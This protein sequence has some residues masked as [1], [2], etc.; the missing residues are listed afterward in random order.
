VLWL[1]KNLGFL[2]WRFM[3]KK[4]QKL[5]RKKNSAETPQKT[6]FSAVFEMGITPSPQPLYTP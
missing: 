4:K 2:P 6:N 5:P 1:I 3:A